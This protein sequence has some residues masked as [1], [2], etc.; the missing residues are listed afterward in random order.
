MEALAL[1]NEAVSLI[2]QLP[3]SKIKYVIQFTKFISQQ[4]SLDSETSSKI[5][6][7]HLPLG[8]L[9]GKAKVHFSDDWE[10]TPEELLGL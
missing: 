2:E 1:K 3:D 7:K 8:F 10:I 6:Q 4:E 9:K 5:S